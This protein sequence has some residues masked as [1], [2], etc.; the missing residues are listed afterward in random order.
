MI[1]RLFGFCDDQ[2]RNIATIMV[3]TL[4]E[5]KA[6][7]QQEMEQLKSEYENRF[8]TQ[9]EQI[10]KL[11]NAVE[12]ATKSAVERDRRTRASMEEVARERL[13]EKERIIAELR[14]QLASKEGMER[15]YRRLKETKE[16]MEQKMLLMTQQILDTFSRSLSDDVKR[17]LSL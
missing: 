4:D 8:E 7:L 10:D 17:K 5:E 9:K 11:R 12:S 2:E 13:E 15:S 1:Y 16:E 3:E 6:G 14:V